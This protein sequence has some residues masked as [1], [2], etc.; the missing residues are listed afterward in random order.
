MAIY[1]FKQLIIEKSNLSSILFT[2]KDAS[3]SNIKN[4]KQKKDESEGFSEHIL[5][6][7]LDFKLPEGVVSTI[8]KTTE[9]YDE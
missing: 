7:G 3:E 5:E 4:N 6:E 8:D 2:G 9:V 1:Y